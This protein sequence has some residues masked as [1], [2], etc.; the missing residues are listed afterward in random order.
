[1]SFKDKEIF[2]TWWNL[3]F[4]CSRLEQE[5]VSRNKRN[6]PFVIISVL[7]SFLYSVADVIYILISN[8]TQAD[9]PNRVLSYMLCFANLFFSLFY[10]CKGEKL[11]NLAL[12]FS[13]GLQSITCAVFY[14]YMHSINSLSSIDSLKVGF[15]FLFSD[16]TVKLF[17]MFLF[18]LSFFHVLCAS[19]AVIV[20]DCVY[21][22]FQGNINDL[23]VFL[24]FYCMF[25]VLLLWLSFSSE[26]KQRQL[27]YA[28]TKTKRRRG[29]ISLFNQVNSGYIN[30]RKSKVSF[31][32][33]FVFNNKEFFERNEEDVVLYKNLESLMKNKFEETAEESPSI[34]KCEPE[35]FSEDEAITFLQTF[36]RE[37]LDL[38][39]SLLVRKSI[40]KKVMKYYNSDK[41]DNLLSNSAN[42]QPAINLDVS[43]IPDHCTK[44]KQRRRDSDEN[45]YEMLLCNKQNFEN[46]TY[47]GKTQYTSKSGT[48]M[49]SLNIFIR[50]KEDDIELVLNDVSKEDIGEGVQQF[51]IKTGQFLHDFK[52]PLLCIN[53]ELLDLRQELSELLEPGIEIHPDVNKLIIMNERCEYMEKISEYCQNMI[54]SYENFSKNIFKP[55]EVKINLE[56]F[57]LDKLLSF[58]DKLMEIRLRRSNKNVEFVLV[59]EIKSSL[60]VKSDQNRIKQILINVLSNSE[61]FTSRGSIT[62]RVSQPKKDDQNLL[63][64][65]IE[66]TGVGMDLSQ[67]KKLF[68]PFFSNNSSNNINGCGLGLII[69][70]DL[71]EK[72][73]NGLD[74]HSILGKGTTVSFT[75]LNNIS[76]EEQMDFD[77]VCMNKEQETITHNNST[78][79]LGNV[80]NPVK[81][82]EDSMSFSNS[83][84]KN[85]HKH[86][87]LTIELK[88]LSSL[89][90]EVLTLSPVMNANNKF[91]KDF[92]ENRFSPRRQRNSGNLQISQEAYFQI[93][94]SG[95]KKSRFNTIQYE[96]IPEHVLSEN[97]LQKLTRFVEQLD[98]CN[99]KNKNKKMTGTLTKISEMAPSCIYNGSNIYTQRRQSTTYNENPLIQSND[100]VTPVRNYTNQNFTIFTNKFY[101]NINQCSSMSYNAMNYNNMTGTEEVSNPGSPV[102]NRRVVSVLVVDDARAIRN[103]YLNIFEKLSKEFTE[104]RFN[105]DQ[106]DDGLTA[107]SKIVKKQVESTL[108][109]N[110]IILDDEMNYMNG[111]ELIKL[112]NYMV[113][114]NLGAKGGFNE[115]LLRKIVIC[116][117]GP[118]NIK[119]KVKIADEMCY[120]KPLSVDN[121]RK[122]VL[123]F[124]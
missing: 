119:N 50:M 96:A 83:L 90:S 100:D 44:F 22:Q 106:A 5:F 65:V 48:K 73:G 30:I 79:G 94:R 13:Y 4:K 78:E 31:I 19:L 57:E 35:N 112:I 45:M 71:S 16:I 122:I 27:Y 54:G 116:S 85:S 21:F 64:F 6:N 107:F 8:K 72:L 84:V 115:E 1:M 10:L 47:L 77:V 49:L 104:V 99:N 28:E 24:L 109:Y 111:S 41:Q 63:K 74:V 55:S 43:E 70:K 11:K 93:N 110:L 25:I 118:E 52:N 32:N 58:V 7:L 61:K 123:K 3:T 53:Q 108:F 97:N 66:D 33:K 80:Q 92:E 42:R 36:L 102:D 29:D 37:F 9:L 60:L 114:H 76:P 46:Y 56:V 59:N 62:L 113:Q 87:P 98:V 120:P 69:V 121:L 88:N 15:L 12:A 103:S 34:L 2:S 105:I 101:R 40:L 20:F 124:M 17:T 95:R 18:Q 82:E 26:L 14:N 89:G 81:Q 68:T 91:K 51:I 86:R 39:E 117:A 38:N 67:T 75:I 23:F